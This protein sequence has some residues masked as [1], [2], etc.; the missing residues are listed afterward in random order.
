MKISF[1]LEVILLMTIAS[2][3]KI[4]DISTTPRQFRIR[5]KDKVKISGTIMILNGGITEL[6]TEDNNKM[7]RTVLVPANDSIKDVVQCA[8]DN[9][10]DNGCRVGL[11]PW[12]EINGYYFRKTNFRSTFPSVFKYSSIV[13]LDEG[14]SCSLE[15]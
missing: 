1:P 8:Y 9:R 5:I 11:T 13:I 3:G 12:I 7:E 2:C 10:L 4:N 6:I 14:S 15:E